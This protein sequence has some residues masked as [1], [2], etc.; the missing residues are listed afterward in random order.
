MVPVAGFILLK[1]LQVG[2]F[3]FVLIGKERETWEDKTRGTYTFDLAEKPVE[4]WS[5]DL[6][7]F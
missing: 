1:P 5:F 2:D 4:K 7:F 6:A 3:L